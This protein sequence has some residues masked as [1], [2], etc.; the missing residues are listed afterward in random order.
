[1]EVLE[2][3]LMIH[4]LAIELEL[5]IEVLKLHQHKFVFELNSRCS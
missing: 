3:G 1:M 5:R 4:H 2:L